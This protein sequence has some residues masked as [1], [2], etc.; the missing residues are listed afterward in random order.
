MAIIH[1][2][3]VRVAGN[4]SQLV[5][6]LQ[7]QVWRKSIAQDEVAIYR[8]RFQVI[9]MRLFAGQTLVHVLSSQQPEAGFEPVEPDLEDFYFAT[10]RGFIHR[11][12]AVN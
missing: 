11:T 7:G 9:S 8:E 6:E 10:I 5:A 3:Q 1:E 2:G 4:P 12:A